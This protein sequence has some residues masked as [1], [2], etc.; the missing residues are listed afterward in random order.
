[1]GACGKPA[2]RRDWPAAEFHSPCRVAIGREHAE[3]CRA[4]P[5]SIPQSATLGRGIARTLGRA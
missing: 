4:R 2:T 5:A 3:Q 1:M